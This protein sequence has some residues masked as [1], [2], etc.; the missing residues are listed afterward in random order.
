MNN[1]IKSALTILN[2][3]GISILDAARLVKSIID[4]NNQ[5]IAN[6]QFCTK[7]I[8]SGLRHYRTT[9]MS[10][11]EGLKIYIQAKSHL[12]PESLRD[13][14]Y[15]SKRLMRLSPE[16]S[17]K[18][19]S[20]F[21]HINCEECISKAFATP[22]QFNKARAMLHTLFAFAVRRE[23]CDKNPISLI[24]RRR[25]VEKE[26]Q[27]L[28]IEQTQSLIANANRYNCEAAVALLV[29]AGIRPKEVRRLSWSDIDLAENS[30]TIRSVCSKTGGIRQVEICPALKN[31]LTRLAQSSSEICPRN[32]QTKWRT[33]RNQ[34][35]FKERWIQDVLRHTYA[36]Y[37][38]KHYRD[39]SRLQLNMGHR[40]QYLL[41][42][43]YV[44]MHG[45]TQHDAHF[46]FKKL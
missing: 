32:W 10:F 5:S 19:F 44:N 4:F 9:E 7:I 29:M 17:R 13:I 6:I 24:E 15:L 41:R 31:H 33:I 2:G 22:S 40:D 3:S 1:E 43:R 16:I 28:T 18:N 38:A 23:W 21:S 39:L 26:I 12:R 34:S 20:E 30:I 11:L 37:H 45:I 14:R 46:F 35:G 42:S 25:V 8:Q 27:P 36:S